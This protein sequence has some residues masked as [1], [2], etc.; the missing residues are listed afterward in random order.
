MEDTTDN[1]GIISVN[2]GTSLSAISSGTISDPYVEINGI[3]YHLAGS[4]TG[5]VY[6]GT[7]SGWKLTPGEDFG[8]YIRS[9][10]PINQI[11]EEQRQELIDRA[12]E[13]WD[14]KIK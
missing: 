11:S 2:N 3:R 13:L 12:K 4:G 6:T 10:P 5:I 14:S 9:N 1:T 7:E 8:D